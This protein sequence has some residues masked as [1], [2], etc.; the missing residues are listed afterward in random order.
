VTSARSVRVILCDDH[1]IVRDGIAR[2]LD[3]YDDIDVIGTAE[4]GEAGVEATVRLRPNVVLM[5]L[6]MPIVDGVQ[7]TRR[8]VAAAPE[9]AVVVLTSFGEQAL[10]MEAIDAGASGF[11]L[12]D[13]APS[14]LVGAIRSAARGEAPLD[15]RV[16]RAVMSRRQ[17]NQ[18]LQEMTAREREVLALVAAGLSN[19]LIARRLG[20]TEATVKAHLTHIYRRIGVDSRVQAA[21]W[22]RQ[23]GLDAS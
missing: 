19:K 18:P 16:A 14:E 20:I 6:L 11:I 2:V 15:P 7:A 12:K 9:T 8:I 5:D 13:A 22:A 10:V 1:A 21:L 23:H 3:A 4:N 17:E